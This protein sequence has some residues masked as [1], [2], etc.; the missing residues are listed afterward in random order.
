M[1]S[2]KTTREDMEMARENMAILL[3]SLPTGFRFHP[4][5]EEAIN[6]Y[7]KPKVLGFSDSNGIIPVVDILE[8]EPQD[9]PAVIRGKKK[10]L[11]QY[12]VCHFSFPSQE[13]D[14]I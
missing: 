6:H 9:L 8:F 7:L 1:H 12:S 10:H 14:L 5:R 11:L 3:K 13:I 4:T 2:V